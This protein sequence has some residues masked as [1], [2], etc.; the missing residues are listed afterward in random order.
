ME[1]VVV[2]MVIIMLAMMMMMIDYFRV[3]FFSYLQADD[4]DDNNDGDD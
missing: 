1:G 2:V 3:K 4:Y